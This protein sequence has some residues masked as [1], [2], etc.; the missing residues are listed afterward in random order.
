VIITP[1]RHRTAAVLGLLVLG[2]CGASNDRTP[3][4]SVREPTARE[5]VAG[6]TV[7]ATV[8]DV[9]LVAA[10][11]SAD[12]GIEEGVRRVNVRVVDELAL[13]LRIESAQDVVLADPPFVCLIGPS[14]IRWMPA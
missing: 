4:P 10:S 5:L 6:V 7:S 9:S 2:G 14:G 3:R 13:E 11:G 8:A 12:F 1:M